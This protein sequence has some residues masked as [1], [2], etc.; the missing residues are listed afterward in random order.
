VTLLF[1]LF[2]GLPL[3]TISDKRRVRGSEVKKALDLVDLTVDI[4]RL[5]R[6]EVV[7]VFVMKKGKV[8]RE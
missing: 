8:E 4:E 2:I 1:I 7:L 6:K 3:T 5:G